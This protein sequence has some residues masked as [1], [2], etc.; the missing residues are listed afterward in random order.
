MINLKCN[1][2]S[3]INRLDAYMQLLLCQSPETMNGLR[4]STQTL[5]EGNVTNTNF[6]RTNNTQ[7]SI[8]G[9][10]RAVIRTIDFLIAYCSLLD[11]KKSHVLCKNISVKKTVNDR[12]FKHSL[13]RCLLGSFW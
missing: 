2:M 1:T 3:I 7:L 9:E 8:A 13:A 12:L 6:E 10:N 11:V 4:T 5:P